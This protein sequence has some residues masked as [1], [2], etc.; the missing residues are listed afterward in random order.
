ETL[1]VDV[2][3]ISATNK[4][5]SES[6]EQG[7]FRSDLFY[8]L[9]VI[10]LFIPPLR[11]RAEDAPLLANRFLEDCARK[12]AKS[13]QGFTDEALEALVDYSWPGNVREAENRV[14]RWGVL[15]QA[16]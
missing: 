5:L 2:R 4:V 8:R 11:E 14:E 12:A 1:E 6:M 9:N 13:F 16:D 3:V 10:P 15:A 7:T